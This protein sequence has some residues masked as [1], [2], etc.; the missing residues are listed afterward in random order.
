MKVNDLEL[1]TK[2]YENVFEFKQGKTVKKSGHTSRH[3]TDSTGECDITLMVY[4]DETS[5]EAQLAGGSGPA[6]HHWG[7]EAPE[8]RAVL[9][10][11]IEAMGGTVLSKPDAVALKFRGPDGNVTEIMGKDGYAEFK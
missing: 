4:D 9:A 10:K 1:S 6:I 8:D 5:P 2:F 7:M 3:M 11:R